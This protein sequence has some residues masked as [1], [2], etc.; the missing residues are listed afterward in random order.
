MR[1]HEG[2]LTEVPVSTSQRPAISPRVRRISKACERSL[3]RGKSKRLGGPKEEY[4][5]GPI[6]HKSNTSHPF[7]VHRDHASGKSPFFHLSAVPWH[8]L[9][10]TDNSTSRYGVV[11][12]ITTSIATLQYPTEL[13]T[14]T[15]TKRLT[16]I[17]VHFSFVH[18]NS[19]TESPTQISLALRCALK[20]PEYRP[21]SCKASAHQLHR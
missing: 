13:S 18:N 16:T 14:S 12:A 19:R 21:R 5:K 11:N 2:W 20:Q 6:M 7:F 8:Q 4:D 17:Q 10:N 9:D 15:M 3:T 1:P